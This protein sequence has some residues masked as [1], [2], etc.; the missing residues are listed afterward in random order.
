M[1]SRLVISRCQRVLWRME[2][3]APS[4][5]RLYRRNICPQYVYPPWG[6]LYVLSKYHVSTIWSGYSEHNL[7]LPSLQPRSSLTS[8][9][10]MP[11]V[12]FFQSKLFSETCMKCETLGMI[13]NISPPSHCTATTT[14]PT[15]TSTSINQH[16]PHLLVQ[17]PQHAMTTIAMDLHQL[18]DT[19]EETLRNASLY[20]QKLPGSSI[21]IRYIK[22]SYQDDPIRSAVELF[23]FLFAVRYLLAPSYSVQ[24]SKGYVDFTDDVSYIY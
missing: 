16:S 17:T 9:V 5:H 10:F 13:C 19:I 1:H 20:F 7:L 4:G 21:F 8:F 18:Q 14:T 2:T 15:T 22:S 6:S 24:K 12:T 23:L 3:D 11:L